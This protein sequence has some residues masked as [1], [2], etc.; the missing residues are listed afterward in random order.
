MRLPRN[1][2][3]GQLAVLLR[4][5]Y[6]YELV[7]QTGSH[8]RLATLRQGEHRVTIPVGSDLRIGTLASILG[9]VAL[10]FGETRNQVVAR[11][12]ES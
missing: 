6:G 3:G 10:H 4:R 8:M 2:S 12:F 11:L 9:D 1:L 7:R 5:H